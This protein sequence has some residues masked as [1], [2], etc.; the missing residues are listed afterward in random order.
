MSVRAL[1]AFPCSSILRPLLLDG[2][3]TFESIP[4]C[5][6]MVGRTLE[7]EADVDGV[8]ELVI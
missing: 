4:F 5:I 6:Q 3:E 1:L 8:V 7:E 2:T